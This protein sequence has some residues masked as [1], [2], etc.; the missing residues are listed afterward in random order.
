MYSFQSKCTLKEIET[1]GKDAFGCVNPST[2]RLFFDATKVNEVLKKM[3][4]RGEKIVCMTLLDKR[5]IPS[6]EP[7]IFQTDFTITTDKEKHRCS[8]TGKCFERTRRLLDW[9][10]MECEL[11]DLTEDLVERVRNAK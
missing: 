3:R 7:A 4:E 9:L 1:M 2:G 6:E 10:N 8:D 5:R 11:N